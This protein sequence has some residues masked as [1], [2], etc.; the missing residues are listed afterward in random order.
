MF[1]ISKSLFRNKIISYRYLTSFTKLKGS[2]IIYNKLIEKEVQDVFIYSGGAIMPL[3]DCFYNSSI[4]YYIGTNE[5]SLGLSAV[6]YAKSS[7]KPG[8]CIV[9]SG[10]GLTNMVTPLTDAQ[11]DS[12]PLIVLSGQVPLNSM[13]TD[14]FQ[15]CPATEITK[16]IT[17]W[18][19]CVT[20]VSELDD[21]MDEAFKISQGGKP[22]SVH[23]DLPKCVLTNHYKPSIKK[24]ISGQ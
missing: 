13:G 20:D 11:N 7:N 10:P 1:S 16:S 14:A 12:T 23:I 15:E 18:N 22:G 24:F 9:T 4:N 19:Y 5:L 17:K 6:G 8:I 21:V 2:N 3:I